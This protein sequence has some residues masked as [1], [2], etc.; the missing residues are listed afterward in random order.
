MVRRFRRVYGRYLQGFDGF[1]AGYPPCFSLFYGDLSRPTLAI[2]AT[3]YEYPLTHDGDR[4]HWLDDALRQG[5]ADRWLTLAA[6]NRADAD[7]LANYTGLDPAYIPSACAY[8]GATYTGGR[9]TALISTLRQEF[10]N[11]VA[12]ELKQ[13]ALPLREA[14]GTTYS[15]ESLYDCRALVLIPYN[16]STMALFEAYTACMPIYVPARDFLKQLFAT[17]PDEVLCHLSFSQV[18][19]KPAAAPPEGAID[20]NQVSDPSVVDWYLDRADFYSEEWMPQVRKFES[21]AH[22]DELLAADDHR[23]I[24]ERMAAERPHRLARISALW[25]SLDWL[26][27]VRKTRGQGSSA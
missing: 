24:S 15:W 17:Y 1:I 2:A 13:E 20:L 11:E 27:R 8:T 22:L 7:Y 3:R 9:S 25:D 26:T 6:N 4:W 21:W 23:A 18:M 10:G 19:G 14:L 5:V 12:G 16:V